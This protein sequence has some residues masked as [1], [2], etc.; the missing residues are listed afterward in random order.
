MSGLQAPCLCLCTD[1]LDYAAK[2]SKPQG[3]TA[4]YA[5]PEH[6]QSLQ[7]KIEGLVDW[8]EL[9]ISGPAADAWSLG[10][11]LY[12]MLT[13]QLPFYSSTLEPYKPP[14]A[15]VDEQHRAFWE[16]N[17]QALALQESWVRFDA[18]HHVHVCSMFELL[19]DN[20]SQQCIDHSASSKVLHVTVCFSLYFASSCHI[21]SGVV[22]APLQHQA[23]P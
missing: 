13:G 23:L 5:A 7:D 9:E 2:C 16:Q 22:Q 6:L 12:E 3:A 8:R 20:K 15:H 21:K 4:P 17:A 1:G 10:V 18:C 11:V 14:P 19:H